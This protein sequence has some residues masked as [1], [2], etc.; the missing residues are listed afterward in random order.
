MAR[1]AAPEGGPNG[2]DLCWP[3][4]A[5]HPDMTKGITK[6]NAVDFAN[7]CRERNVLGPIAK[8]YACASR[9]SIV[10]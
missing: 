7:Y 10:Y 5:R 3:R 2:L 4:F 9:T 8:L 6:D 1:K